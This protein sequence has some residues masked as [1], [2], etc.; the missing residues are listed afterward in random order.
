MRRLVLLLL[1]ALPLALLVDVGTAAPAS[2]HATLVTTTPAESARVETAPTEV[3]LEFDEG[4]SLG[5]GYARVLDSGGERVDTGAAAASDGTITVPLRA[6]LPDA[7]YV[8]TYRV[9]SAD[10]H[11]IS[12]AY[13]F[14]V[15]DGELVP[16]TG[17]DSADDVDPVVG[18]LL[19]VARWLGFAGLALG[20]GV[21]VF[22][23]TCWSAGWRSRRVR[24]L[25]LAGLGA[26]AA[27]GALSFLLQGPY[28][29][30]TGLGDLV[31][32]QLLATTAGSTF[33][34]TLLARVALAGALAGV[35]VAAFRAA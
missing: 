29:A 1:A 17:A 28:A 35:A 30:A 5:A 15:G 8:V 34:L 16:T 14:V 13:A 18:V 24:T 7:S 9:V 23:L 31:D 11:P 33:G 32:P 21:P 27:G 25:T 20:V 26:V 19:P 3:V 10:A 6:D 4:V 12:G 2:A 22:L